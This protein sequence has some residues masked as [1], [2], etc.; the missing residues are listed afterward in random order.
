MVVGFLKGLWGKPA[1]KG[2]GVMGLW[3]TITSVPNSIFKVV[4]TPFKIIAY[5]ILGLIML[6][7]YK[8]L[9]R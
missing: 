7:L 5:A 6:L 3:G 2:S 9:K 1:Q 8:R 4:S